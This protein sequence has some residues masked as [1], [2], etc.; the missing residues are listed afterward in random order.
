MSNPTELP[1]LD[2]RTNGMTDSELIAYCQSHCETERAL[3]NEDQVNR[4]IHLAGYPDWCVRKATG[5][6]SAHETMAKLCELALARRAQPEGEAPQAE[7]C[8]GVYRQHP[9]ENDGKEFFFC[10]MW[11]NETNW[12]DGH[13]VVKGRFVPDSDAPAATLSPAKESS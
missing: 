5:W 7:T 8:Y 13:R 3:F 4:M 6:M 9:E 12:G 2:H 11:H 1:D 10:S